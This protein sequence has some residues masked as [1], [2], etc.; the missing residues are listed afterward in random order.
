MT[1]RE[2]LDF[3]SRCLG[4]G[5]KYELLEQL[6]EREKQ[7]GIKPDP[8]IDAYMKGVALNSTHETSLVIEYVL[9]VSDFLYL[10]C[11]SF[12]NSPNLEYNTTE[13]VDIL[14]I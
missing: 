14:F 13:L 6:L 1:V 5:T 12:T 11:K 8:E 9:K 2:T 4:V 10:H 3:A 7:A